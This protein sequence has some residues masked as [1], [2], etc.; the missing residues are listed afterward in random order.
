VALLV[1]VM[2]LEGTASAEGGSAKVRKAMTAVASCITGPGGAGPLPVASFES[3]VTFR[4]K[5]RFEESGAIAFGSGNGL[6]F[7]TI[8]E[9]FLV[10]SGDP[11]L[12]HGWATWRV[13]GG[14]GEFEGASGVIRSDFVLQASGEIRDSQFGTIFVK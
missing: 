1:Y 9:G 4:G 6:R 13:E 3:E 14:F 12:K 2:Q 7:R 10:P 5:G 8:G 11:G